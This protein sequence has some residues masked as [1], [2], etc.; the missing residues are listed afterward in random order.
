MLYLTPIVIWFVLSTVRGLSPSVSCLV[1]RY[2]TLCTDKIRRGS[3]G[4]DVLSTITP[5]RV[6]YRRNNHKPISR[7]LELEKVIASPTE[8]SLVPDSCTVQYKQLY[9]CTLFLLL[10]CC[11]FFQRLTRRQTDRCSCDNT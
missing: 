10:H 5:S 7:R 8:A 4:M 6:M 3:G 2:S 1:S 9:M 11:D